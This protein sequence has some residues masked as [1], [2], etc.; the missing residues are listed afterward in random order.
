MSNS[1]T[2]I[3]ITKEHMSTNWAN[4]G[5]QMTYDFMVSSI[6]ILPNKQM[7]SVIRWPVVILI[8]YQ[9]KLSIIW[10]GEVVAI[11][12]NKLRMFSWQS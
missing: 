2:H 1:D 3:F 8:K 7:H 10:S 9:V 4:S 11:Y 5:I 12:M 6:F